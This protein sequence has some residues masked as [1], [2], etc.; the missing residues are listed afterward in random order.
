MR[1]VWGNKGQRDVTDERRYEDKAQGH[2][3]DQTHPTR[4]LTS[5]GAAAQTLMSCCRGVSW[6]GFSC[7]ASLIHY[8][9][10]QKK[11]NLRNPG[12]TPGCNVAPANGQL[13]GSRAAPLAPERPQIKA[14]IEACVHNMRVA[15]SCAHSAYAW[16]P[17]S[18]LIGL[19]ARLR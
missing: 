6:C 2:P 7:V 18:R 13:M 14:V 8:K 5:Q 15:G 4:R 12:E 19:I 17:V 9:K 1:Y 3:V 11:K 16:K 10:N